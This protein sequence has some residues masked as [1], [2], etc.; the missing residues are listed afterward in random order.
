LDHTDVDGPF[1]AS[2]G[3]S[4]YFMTLMEE[5]TRFI[6]ATPIQSTGM[7]PDVLKARIKQLETLTGLK[8]K[9][10]RHD[11][12]M[13][14]VSRDLQSWYEDEGI[15]SE[16]TAP[17]SSQ[18]NGKAERVYWYIIERVRAALLDAGVE[19]E[20]WAAT[21]SSVIHSPNRSPTAV[22]DV[23]PLEALTGGRPEVKGFRVWGRRA[24]ALKPKQQ[25]RN[26]EPT[27]DVGHIVG[28]T[29]GGKAYRIL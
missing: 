9:R 19:E 3:G 11:G 23:T 5:S 22:Q 13:E 24:W 27:T 26:L 10:V 4:V 15:L 12:A 8:L 1:T 7:V 17:Y 14:Y 25:Q 16:K 21:F 29:V 28:Y 20:P 18:K 2:L 6:T